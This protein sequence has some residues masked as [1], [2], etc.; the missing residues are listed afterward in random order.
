MNPFEK[1]NTAEIHI[2][3]LGGEPRT[4]PQLERMQV[5]LRR[6]DRLELRVG[7]LPVT[8]MVA[9]TKR[10]A[11]VTVRPRAWQEAI[12]ER[13]D[14]S[15][16]LRTIAVALVGE[17]PRC[18]RFGVRIDGMDLLVG[19]EKDE[20]MRMFSLTV[21]KLQVDRLHPT[22]EVIFASVRGPFL[23]GHILRE[24]C[25]SSHVMLGSGDLTLGELE[26]AV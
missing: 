14:C 3:R 16:N 18:E 19:A 13:V 23:K 5:D 4:G 26:A 11:V 12:V 21:E 17:T 6:R 7:G 25:N 10:V 8:V 22:P 15:I 1:G 24:D 2:T 20:D 9:T